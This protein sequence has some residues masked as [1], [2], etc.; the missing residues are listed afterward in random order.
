[1]PTGKINVLS[2]EAK[3]RAV[4]SNKG[5]RVTLK[6]DDPVSALQA[7][8]KQANIK[9][10]LTPEEVERISGAGK[11]GISLSYADDLGGA[12][13]AAKKIDQLAAG[14]LA[15]RLAGKGK[16]SIWRVLG[17]LVLVLLLGAVV[18]VVT[19]AVLDAIYGSRILSP[20]LR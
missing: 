20:V 5:G 1:M 7:I 2:V 15:V 19:V 8:A 11:F 9:I 16:R 12:T 17:L 14:A 10:D 6:A 4:L 18:F 13:E 3:G